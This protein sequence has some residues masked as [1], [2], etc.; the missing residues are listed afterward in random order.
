MNFNNVKNVLIENDQVKGI[1]DKDGNLLWSKE[2]Y[3]VN[4]NGDITQQTYSG[5]NLFSTGFASAYSANNDNSFTM[6][7]PATR[8]V[9]F[10]FPT[11]LPAGTYRFSGVVTAK[12][13]SGS[14][15]WAPYSSSGKI[16]SDR[17]IS[18][19]GNFSTTFTSSV[20]IHHIYFFISGSENDGVYVSF[21]KVQLES[22]SSSTSFEPYVGGVQAPNPDYPQ[23]INVVTGSQ[24]III[25][26][27]GYNNIQY[28]VNLGSIELCKLGTYQDY[29]YKDNG[30]WYIHKEITKITYDGTEDWTYQS[31]YPRA[32]TSRPADMGS[33]QADY[34]STSKCS[35]FIPGRTDRDLDNVYMIGGSAVS[36]RSN[37]IMTSKANWLTWLTNNNVTLYYALTTAT[38]TQITDGTLIQQLN[39]INNIL[40]KYGYTS[41]VVGSLP[42]II[43]TTPL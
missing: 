29:I 15:Y 39:S 13:T 24:N 14:V 12:T 18:S 20:P 1:H 10:V 28:N 23:T 43:S 25:S 30:N 33:V 11:E 5:K 26:D 22:G 35:H 40:I 32:Y 16:G 19:T 3:T 9:N 38:D 31:Q 42:I 4:Y 21:N 27:G 34:E 7:K 17:S 41:T 2:V 6:T 36:F 37:A 8:T